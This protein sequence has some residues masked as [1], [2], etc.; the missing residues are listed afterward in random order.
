MKKTS[1]PIIELAILT[2][3][4]VSAPFMP[5]ASIVAAQ[6][7]GGVV[8]KPNTK[9]SAASTQQRSKHRTKP[10]KSSSGAP[11]RVKVEEMQAS[12]QYDSYHRITQGPILDCRET[13]ERQ[14]VP[15]ELRVF[16]PA[17][18]CTGWFIFNPDPAKPTF[19]YR[20]QWDP[21]G[22]VLEEVRD[23][24]GYG[25]FKNSPTRSP[26]IGVIGQ[27]IKGIRFK[28]LGKP[29]RVTFL[30][31]DV[32][33]V[34]IL[35]NDTNGPLPYQISKNGSWEE[36]TLSPGSRRGHS[37]LNNDCCRVR[38]DYKYEA[39]S[40]PK[41]YN[42]EVTRI[43]GRVPTASERV[44]AKVNYFSANTNGEIILYAAP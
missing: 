35:R 10:P 28:A 17:N 24:G 14:L 34:A 36:F 31:G 20:L 40:Q 38:Y 12:T 41:T 9:P 22:D 18:S 11:S 25:M 29:V 39:G 27:R 26:T 2:M 1:S 5:D 19:T 23:R 13:S 4:F 3:L 32:W 44:K 42:A 8:A 33:S 6:P 43:V 37:W 21:D 16:V 7:K 15:G 30:I